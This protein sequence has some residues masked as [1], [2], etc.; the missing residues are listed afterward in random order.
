MTREQWRAQ[1]LEAW[2]MSS[3]RLDGRGKRSRCAR[4][5]WT[6]LKTCVITLT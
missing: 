1:V 5:E 6:R 2:E 3:K 4:L